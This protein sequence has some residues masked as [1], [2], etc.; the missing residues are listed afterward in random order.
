[1]NVTPISNRAMTGLRKKIAAMVESGVTQSRIAVESGVRRKDLESWLESGHA[2]EQLEE[3]LSAWIEDLERPQDG[4]SE[5]KW[6]E[7]PTGERIKAALEFARTT[8]SVSVVYGPAGLGKTVTAQRYAESI[9]RAHVLH[10]KAGE[11]NKTPTAIM[12]LIAE[13]AGHAGR[14]YRSDE[15]ARS[16]VESMP[17]SSL[18][19]LDEAQH[20]SM[21][22]L[23]GI[24]WLY[25]EGGIGLALVGNEVVY[26]RIARG[27]RAMF[28]QLES[29]VGMYLPLSQPEPGDLDAVLAAWGVSGREERAFAKQ[30]AD[31]PGALRVLAHVLRQ[32]QLAA[33]VMK[34][35]VDAALM[36]GALDARGGLQ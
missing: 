34:R 36:R 26:T 22:A 25:D 28:A 2:A 18:V 21:A 11:F 33:R 14:A 23:D 31:G 9:G 19:I 17:R 27:G 29:R 3:R 16:I 30:I 5:P 20:L 15:L 8:P 35:P 1:M 24:R 12:Q 32:A 6:V 10:V 7:T 4:G 13:K